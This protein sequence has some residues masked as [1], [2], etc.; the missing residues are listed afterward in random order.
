MENAITAIIKIFFD[1]QIWVTELSKYDMIKF[2]VKIHQKI[3]FVSEIKEF[4]I[5]IIFLSLLKIL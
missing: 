1:S 2:T 5:L 4:A 3:N